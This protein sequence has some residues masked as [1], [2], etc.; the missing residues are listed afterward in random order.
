MSKRTQKQDLREA[1]EKFE[2][3]VAAYVV[4]NPGV[5]LW[6]VGELFGI[7]RREVYSI[8]KRRGWQVRGHER[9]VPR[10]NNQKKETTT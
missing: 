5:P 6:K 1:R 2:G 3:E 8:R 9:K 4:A 10:V 7:D